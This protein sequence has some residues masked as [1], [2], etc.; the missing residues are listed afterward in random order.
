[1]SEGDAEREFLR[2]F[3]AER[4]AHCPQCGYNLRALTSDVCPE[5]GD[6]IVI[7]VA[8]AEPKQAA[9]ITGLIGLSAAAGLNGLLII[10]W[11][12]VVLVLRPGMGG[13]MV[14]FLVFNSIGLV[15]LGGLIFGWLKSWRR[16]IRTTPRP[17]WIA[18]SMCWVVALVDVVSFIAVLH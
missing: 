1:M 7:R 5:C 11:A 4:D 14:S 17:R 8:M 16:I 15:V 10:Y 6:R 9:A 18:A 2:Q 3:L 13:E 12:V